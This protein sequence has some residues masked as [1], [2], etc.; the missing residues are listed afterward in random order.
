VAG[1][2]LDKPWWRS[3]VT[4]AVDDA[5][6]GIENSVCTVYIRVRSKEICLA[7]A[8]QARMPCHRAT[9]AHIELEETRCPPLGGAAFEASSLAHLHRLGGDCC[10]GENPS[11]CC[12]VSVIAGVC[13]CE[14]ASM[15]QWNVYINSRRVECGQ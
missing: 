13:V 14:Y 3:G 5:S 1:T 6:K 15:Q 10:A 7:H 9:S 11:A 4:F 8:F 12:S 2:A